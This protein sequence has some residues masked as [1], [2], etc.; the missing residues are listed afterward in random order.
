MSLGSCFG[1]KIRIE[2]CDITSDICSR[3]S[4]FHESIVR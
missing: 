3:K 1:E 2:S 4:K